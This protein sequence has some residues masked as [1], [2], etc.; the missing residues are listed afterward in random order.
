[1]KIHK[2]KNSNTKTKSEI[3]IKKPKQQTSEKS[4]TYDRKKAQ[5]LPS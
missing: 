1:M 3:E 5:T 2:Q 4:E